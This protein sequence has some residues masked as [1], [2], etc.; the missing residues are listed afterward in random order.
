MLKK[1]SLF[2]SAATLLVACNKYKVEVKDGV[3][4]QFHSHDDNAKKLKDGDIVTFNIEFKNGSDSVLQSSYK[5]GKPAKAMIQAAGASGFKGSFED[6][7]RL[8]AIGD[9]ATIF[10]P[11][12]SIAKN[13]QQMLPPFIKR[14]TDLKYTVKVVKVQTK[15]EFEKEMK[16]EADKAKVESEKR[17]AMVPQLVADYVAKS[18]KKFETAKSGLLYS[19]SAPGAGENAKTGQTCTV[20]YV[21]KFLDGKIFDQNKSADMPIGQMIPGF[22][23]AMTMM[24]KGGKGT[25]IIPPSI[26]YGEEE[27]GPIPG[28]SIL[29]F[30]VEVLDIKK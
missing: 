22:N 9:S 26:G 12:D 4:I 10:V 3:K 27:R 23:E 7:L 15:A 1:I 28:N 30:E 5:D 2:L 17:K 25:F 6:G 14:G 13:P 24:K 8:L 20:S 18:G 29:V 16:A 19:I 11:V 21:G